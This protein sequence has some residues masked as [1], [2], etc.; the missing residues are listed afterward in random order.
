MEAMT[1]PGEA[2]IAVLEIQESDRG[3]VNMEPWKESE[4][5]QGLTLQQSE[6]FDRVHEWFFGRS[7]ERFLLSGSAGSGKSFLV[8]RIVLS[9]QAIVKSG[10]PVA[11]AIAHRVGWGSHRD[12]KG[13]VVRER[14]KNDVRV[15]LCAPTNAAVEVLEGFAIESGLAIGVETLH[16]LLQV[17]PG[18][19]DG[20]GK[21]RLSPVF[22]TK[23]PYES[24]GLVVVDEASML[25]SSLLALIPADVPTLFTGDPA[26]LPPIEEQDSEPTGEAIESPVFAIDQS[27][28]LTDVVRY[29]GGILR[30]ATHIRNNLDSPNAPIVPTEDGNL[31]GLPRS[32]WKAVMRGVFQSPEAA[33]DPN[34]V[35][36]LAFRNATVNALNAEIRSL[37]YPDATQRFMAGEVLIAKE[38]IFVWDAEKGREAIA[39]HTGQPGVVR[40]VQEGDASIQS[41]ILG[42]LIN[43]KTYKLK[44]T[45]KSGTGILD[46]RCVHDESKAAIVEFLSRWHQAILGLGADQSEG[47][48]RSLRQRHWGSY[49]WALKDFGLTDKYADRLQYSYATTIH[50]AQGSTYKTVFGDFRDINACPSGDRIKNK[51]RYTVLT[52]ASESA[53]ILQ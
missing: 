38:P 1:D 45:V 30:L 19:Y 18:E 5:R 22:S 12:R 48:Q 4:Y 36:V 27:Y 21:Q 26:Q 34:Y 29:D 16:S 11:A 41:N 6:G 17:A 28:H 49:H 20:N 25:S 46:I 2:A 15:V 47:K 37:L 51:L 44:I 35:R 33:I 7:P 50:K 42:E 9:I 53:F 32:A 31:M 40:S 13:K 10:H 43:V 24:Y 3:F 23:D 8:A 14:I 52:R 39:M